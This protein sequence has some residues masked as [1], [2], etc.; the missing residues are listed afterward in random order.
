MA[1]EKIRN[2]NPKQKIKVKYQIDKNH[3]AYWE[4]TANAL[5]THISRIINAFMKKNIKLSNRQL[6]YQ[7]VGR[8]LIPNNIAIYKRICKFLTDLKYGGYID[9][10]AIED[11]GRTPERH[12]EW[13][14]FQDLINSAVASYRL[15]RWQDQRFYVELY[16]EKEAMESVLRPI[17]NKYHI[18]FGTNKGY[19]SS[20][21]IYDIAKRINEQLDNEKIVVILYLGDHDPSGLDMVRDV[22]ER[23]K[24]FLMAW[25]YGDTDPDD[26]PPELTA[27][28]IDDHFWIDHVALTTDQVEEYNPPPNPA[29]IDDPRAGAYISEH[30]EV[31]WELD[32]LD[33]EILMK[34]TEVRIL[35]YLDI[36]KYNEWVRIEKEESQALVEFGKALKE[37]A[38]D[39]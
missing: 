9:W 34:M 23:I 28:W 14:T 33:P 35:E 4:T 24:E 19:T 30:G 2:W 39:S 38:G 17:A 36:D 20:S 16:C 7:L 18:Y 13:E 1:K 26:Y 29:K 6:Y 37:K 11:R 5:Y 12:S 31:S 8:D 3:Y 25:R 21:T 10:D 15:P 27:E 32:S 22:E